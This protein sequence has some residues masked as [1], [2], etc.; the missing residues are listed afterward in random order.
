MPAEQASKPVPGFERFGAPAMA[1]AFV[2]VVLAVQLPRWFHYQQ[3]DVWEYW[4]ARTHGLSWQFVTVNGFEHFAPLERAEHWL[5]LKISPFNVGLGVATIVAL[6]ALLLL[7]VAWLI[8]E[9]DV[10]PTRRLFLLVVGGL[11]MPLFSV[12]SS[13]A[14]A[15]YIIPNMA[16]T[17][18]VMASHARGLRTGS[19]WFHVLA[20]GFLLI[21]VG[22]QERGGIAVALTILMDVFLLGRGE[23]WRKRLHRMWRVRWPILALVVIAATDAV[24][25]RVWYAPPGQQLAHL[26]T[27][28]EIFASALGQYLLPSLIGSHGPLT[29]A[30]L[31]IVGLL[32]VTGIIVLITRDRRALDL[33]AF[34][35]ATFVLYYAGLAFSPLLVNGVAASASF[36][37]YLSYAI[38][39]LLI[40]AALIARSTQATAPPDHR[41][42]LVRHIRTVAVRRRW[43][44]TSVTLVILAGFLILQD[45]R[46]LDG[47]SGWAPSVAQYLNNVRA[48]RSTWSSP[49]ITL[50][51]LQVPNLIANTWVEAE[52][53]EEEFL[54]LV[55]P[56]FHLGPASGAFSILD[57]E[58]QVRPVGASVTAALRMPQLDSVASGTA[59]RENTGAGMC[60]TLRTDQRWLGIS[61]PHQQSQGRMFLALD[62]TAVRSAP[63]Q[64]GTVTAAGTNRANAWPSTITSGHHLGVY[65]LD[66]QSFDALQLSAAT[67]DAQICLRGVAVLQPV[68]GAANTNCSLVDS[69]GGSGAITACGTVVRRADELSQFLEPAA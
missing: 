23:A 50:L 20:C 65:P 58:G 6:V 64:I 1:I 66:G 4:L 3:D 37:A 11:A 68:W 38:F 67:A 47:D 35:C 10:P 56:H 48:D 25:W 13:N 28:A 18:A 12:A 9:L 36:P 15:V 45:T 32:A 60:I 52:G 24:I 33:V 43:L 8:D 29:G 19:R 54:N 31:W 59:V 27:G 14:Q 55:D 57:P 61:V 2:V 7:S 21:A 22:L 16:A 42:R 49:R 34:F 46:T 40:A 5:Q 62:Y 44:L 53:Q 69:Y 51:P 17:Y 39:P 41:V 30:L 63:F 26:R